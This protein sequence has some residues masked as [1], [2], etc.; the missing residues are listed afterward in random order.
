VK[1]QKSDDSEN[2]HLTRS[3][4]TG[5]H[6]NS[7]KLQPQSQASRVGVNLPFLSYYFYQEEIDINKTIEINIG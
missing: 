6:L 1:T 4:H 3:P 5:V 2:E 7:V